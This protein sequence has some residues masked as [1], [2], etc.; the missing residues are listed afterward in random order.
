MKVTE[1]REKKKT[2]GRAHAVTGTQVP[3]SLY[4]QRA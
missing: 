4:W 1:E 3:L 2:L